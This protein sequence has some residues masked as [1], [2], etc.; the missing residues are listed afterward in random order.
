MESSVS[1]GPFRVGLAMASI[2]LALGVV[3]CAGPSSERAHAPAAGSTRAATLPKP[4]SCS[5]AP[6]SVQAVAINVGRVAAFDPNCWTVASGHPFTIVL[7]DDLTTDTGKDV[8]IELSIY[9]REAAAD[10]LDP[11]AGGLNVDVSKALFR[12]AEVLSPGSMTYSVAA[13]PAGTYWV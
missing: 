6:S 10:S 8:P 7:T 13:L 12:G 4:P 9:S 5:P 1:R 2:A 11:S 3:A